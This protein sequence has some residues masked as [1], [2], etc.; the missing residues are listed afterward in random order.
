M[1]DE[2]Q[3]TFEKLGDTGLVLADG[4][5][6]VRGRT[7]VDS[8]GEELGKI[9]GLFVDVG[10]RRLRLLEI[11]DGG[12]LG[13]GGTTRLVPVEA[14]SAVD[15]DRVTVSAHREAV[16][17]SPV[18]DPELADRPTYFDDVYAHYEIGP[19]GMSGYQP[20]GRPFA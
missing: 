2:T 6:D 7:V 9:D 14:V 15:E 18:Y 4:E 16:S 3:V 1:T 20:P 5:V 13:F 17:G 8:D 19:F 12:L 11:S 10:E